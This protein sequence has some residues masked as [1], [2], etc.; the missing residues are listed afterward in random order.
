MTS[1]R[2][3]RR[4]PASGS[5]T[6]AT[7]SSSATRSTVARTYLTDGHWEE[8]LKV[9]EQLEKDLPSEAT[10]HI[11]HGGPVTTADFAWQRHYI[12]TFLAAVKD[13]D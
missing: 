10:L 6:A 13:A 4:T 1:V 8:W 12:E 5:S 9:N 7:T 2:R 11:D 3:S